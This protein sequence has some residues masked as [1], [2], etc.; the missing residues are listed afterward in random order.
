VSL[1][2]NL[3]KLWKDPVWSNVIATGI[4][5]LLGYAFYKGWPQLQALAPSSRLVVSL[6]IGMLLAAFLVLLLR[7][8]SRV[9]P[10]TLVFLSSG[11]TCRDPIAKAIAT[12]LL[13]NKKGKHPII[14]RAAG[15]GPISKQEVSYAARYVIKEIYN[16][17]LL[18]DHKPELLTT[19][20][21]QKADLI[22]AMDKALLLTPGK[23]LSKEKTFLLKE[24][25]GLEGDVS[26]PWPDGKDANTISR[27]RG[28]AEELRQILTQ[29]LD[30]LVQVLDL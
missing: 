12:K 9:A 8:Y 25:F 13:E 17:D 23:T 11:G 6:S 16:E 14:I 2:T 3:L 30:R 7:Q 19:D 21:A 28:C 22:L 5:A 1:R 4:L 24:F 20:L 15:L 29:N 18:A 27:Y 26:D 10:K